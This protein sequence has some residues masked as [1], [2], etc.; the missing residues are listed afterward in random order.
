[1]ADIAFIF[2][3]PPEP[4]AAMRVSEILGWRDKALARWHKAYGGNE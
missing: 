1:M 2:H 4:L 3:W